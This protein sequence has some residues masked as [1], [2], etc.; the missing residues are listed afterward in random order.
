MLSLIVIKALCV[1]TGKVLYSNT[2]KVTFF[3][4]LCISCAK[5]FPHAFILCVNTGKVCINISLALCISCAKGFPHDC[6]VNMY[7]LI[8]MYQVIMAKGEHFIN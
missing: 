1:N 2:C 7:Y 4:T 3:L 5:G 6:V 8:G